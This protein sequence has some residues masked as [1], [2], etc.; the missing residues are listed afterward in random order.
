MLVANLEPIARV[1]VGA[2]LADDR[3][4]VVD[5]GSDVVAQ[6][7][8][9]HADAVVVGGR[10]AHDLG[11]LVHLAVPD[12]KVIVWSSDEEWIDVIDPGSTRPRRNTTPAPMALLTELSTINN[13]ERE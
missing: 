3:F 13:R 8:A 2:L 4:E 9:I 11:R 6:A 5:A 12:A 1:G 10:S 7:A